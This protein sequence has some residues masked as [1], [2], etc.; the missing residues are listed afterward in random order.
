[1][2][3]ITQEE[4][5]KLEAI[6]E[7][8]ERGKDVSE[9]EPF[10]K[11]L[12][13]RNK[14]LGQKAVDFIGD[15]GE[16]FD[17]ISGSKATREAA[18]GELG[19]GSDP[20]EIFGAA[21]S[22]IGAEEFIEQPVFPKVEAPG[23]IPQE[24]R[25]AIEEATGE[26]VSIKKLGGIVTGAALDPTNLA[27]PLVG[28]AAKY[29]SKAFKNIA[30]SKSFK[31]LAQNAPVKELRTLTLGGRTSS[32]GKYILSSIDNVKETL[33]KEDLIPLTNRP[34]KMFK[35]IDLKIS[36]N[37][38]DLY[39]AI[40]EISPVTPKTNRIDLIKDLAERFKQR[41][42][43]EEA[44]GK[45]Y[46]E[47]SV[48]SYL[49]ELKSRTNQ[50]SNNDMS[51]KDLQ[52]LK[53]NIDKDIRELTFDKAKTGLSDQAAA[54]QRN[55]LDIRTDIREIIKEKISTVD[56]VISD[57]V[58]AQN[59]R[60]SGLFDV[61][62]LLKDVDLKELK[63]PELTQILSSIVW[64]GGAGLLA[65][66][67]AGAATGHG[68]FALTGLAA[69]SI[70]PAVRQVGKVMGAQTPGALGRGALKAGKAL[71]SA[72]GVVVPF[73]EGLR[74]QRPEEGQ[75]RTPQSLPEQL[76]RFKIPRT[77]QGVM[78]NA[79]IIIAKTAQQQP[80]MLPTVI[81]IVKNNPER[82]PELMSF[83]ASTMPEM[84]EL[85]EYERFDGAVSTAKMNIARADLMRDPNLSNT[86][87]IKLVNRLNKTG[88]M[89]YNP[90]KLQ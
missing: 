24:A 7:L 21:A 83:A 57:Y 19:V 56:S 58:T 70:Y 85:D 46:D 75:G 63:K 72:P 31:S 41:Y 36:Q 79:D 38:N 48:R 68:G 82:V 5:E 51:V 32:E 10:L 81:D 59:E 69:G 55:L 71:E 6:V 4:R 43:A 13:D 12:E 18:G 52:T 11:S 30:K 22:K 60:I 16:K 1:M 20:E 76:I 89:E 37:T 23:G 50:F 2:E 65:G 67:V 29:A 84:F 8:R 53:R 28:K 61:K 80:E 17:V 35:N 90:E 87:R 77:T 78:K 33:L 88:K 66:S 47:K 34:F 39:K 64:G 15:I 49:N 62:G 40:E 26:P 27:M 86:E 74:S 45:V 3:E 9:F 42:S 25:A 54:T 73:R 44:V 14:S